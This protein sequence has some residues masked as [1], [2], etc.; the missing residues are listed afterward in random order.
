MNHFMEK[1]VIGL[2]AIVV[3]ASL[4]SG[5]NTTQ[6]TTMYAESKPVSA[7][8]STPVVAKETSM[9]EAHKRAAE[10][11]AIEDSFHAPAG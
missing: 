5:C 9:S 10:R 7:E 4:L 2:G 1:A 3:S 11:N 6:D 8:K